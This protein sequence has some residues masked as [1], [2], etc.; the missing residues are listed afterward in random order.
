MRT[1][2]AA[3]GLAVVLPS[4]AAAQ[5]PVTKSPLPSVELPPELARVLTDYEKAYR[6]GGRELAPL[7]AEN[8]FVL[9][10][11]RSPVRGRAAIAAYYGDGGGP[12]SLRAI[13]YNVDGSLGYIIGGYTQE[14]GSPDAG[15]FTL[16]LH[17]GPDGRWLIFSDMDNSNQRN[18]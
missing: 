9:A 13:A 12:L 17:K 15:K 3:F 16:T 4:L 2:I 1:L 7:F 5:Q 8:G 10:G 18:D 11:G 14:Q 6:I